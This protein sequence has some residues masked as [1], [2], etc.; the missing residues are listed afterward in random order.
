MQISIPS[1]TPQIIRQ[2]WL[3]LGIGVSLLCLWLAVRNVSFIELKD[4]L[5]SA[6]YVWLLPAV[7]TV[8]ASVATR[9]WR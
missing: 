2:P 7:V 8:L 5:S 6:R 3:W 4:S 1:S 9:A